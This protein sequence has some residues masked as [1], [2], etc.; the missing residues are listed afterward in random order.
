VV[1]TANNEFV[2]AAVRNVLYIWDSQTGSHVK[3]LNEHFARISALLSVTSD[4]VNNVTSVSIDKTVKVAQPS[5]FFMSVLC[6]V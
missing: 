1:L 3:T 2:V 4:D 5:T 6:H